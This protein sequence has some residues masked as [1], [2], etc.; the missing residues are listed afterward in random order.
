MMRFWQRL[1]FGKKKEEAYKE[2]EHIEEDVIPEASKQSKREAY[3][4][5]IPRSSFDLEDLEKALLYFKEGDESYLDYLYIL[6]KEKDLIAAYILWELEQ[7]ALLAFPQEELRKDDPMY[8]LKLLYRQDYL[9]CAQIDLL[10]YPK[11]LDWLSFRIVVFGKASF[12]V[13]KQ[14]RNPFYEFILFELYCISRREDNYHQKD[15]AFLNQLR[16]IFHFDLFTITEQK[17]SDFAYYL[18]SIYKERD[19]RGTTESIIALA[20]YAI[21]EALIEDPSKWQKREYSSLVFSPYS[22][23][24]FD[25]A[26][27]LDLEDFSIFNSRKEEDLEKLYALLVLHPNL[28]E[29]YLIAG[30]P[31]K[32]LPKEVWS[33]KKLEKLEVSSFENLDEQHFFEELVTL[34]NLKELKLDRS[35]IQRLYK[36]TEGGLNIRRFELIAEGNFDLDGSM[37]TL[38]A[39]P[40]LRELSLHSLNLDQ[41]PPRFGELSSVIELNLSRNEA[42]DIGQVF[43]VL[44]GM[45]LLERLRLDKCDLKEFSILALANLSHL[46]V[47]ENP[48]LDLEDFFAAVAKLPKLNTLYMRESNI[49]AFPRNVNPPTNLTALYLCNNPDLDVESVFKF[50]NGFNVRHLYMKN[51]NLKRLPES[52]VAHSQLISLNVLSNLYLDLEHLLS[53]L[54]KMESHHLSIEIDLPAATKKEWEK[55]CPFL[56]FR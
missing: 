56:S 47:D 28:K 32:Y 40:Q 20:D 35:G 54:K 53:I 50:I 8:L 45:P 15:Y 29:L 19:I 23:N 26:K 38:L 30:E 18:Q 36:C 17:P 2:G 1:L 52:L 37:E 7:L 11:A 5:R 16:G 6:Y 55:A 42:L 24:V 34:P 4:K 39:M 13:L 44:A 25:I 14:K 48:N 22:A 41:L 27:Y 31:R 49:R 12:D 46:S 33:L 51:C 21:S 43:S 3:F 10:R 9:D